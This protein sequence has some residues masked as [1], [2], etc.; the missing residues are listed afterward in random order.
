MQWDF[1]GRSGCSAVC[2]TLRP[3]PIGQLLADLPLGQSACSHQVLGIAGCIIN[4]GLFTRRRVS[5][6]RYIEFIISPAPNLLD[7]PT[8]GSKQL[9]QSARMARCEPPIVC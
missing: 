2:H 9:G 4:C 8:P 1:I 3:Q 6:L 7:P 5:L